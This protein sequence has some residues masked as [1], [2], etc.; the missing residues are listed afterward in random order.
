MRIA[1]ILLTLAISLPVNSS[2]PDYES[3]VRVY[4]LA[5]AEGRIEIAF[6][7]LNELQSLKPRY[8]PQLPSNISLPDKQNKVCWFRSPKD[9]RGVLAAKEQEISDL[10]AKRFARDF[11]QLPT[12][13]QGDLI[14]LHHSPFR[15]P[16]G[17]QEELIKAMS[18]IG[19]LINSVKRGP[20]DYESVPIEAEVIDVWADD[21]VLLSLDWLEPEEP[22]KEVGE[23]KYISPSV[24]I[25]DHAPLEYQQHGFEFKMPLVFVSGTE[26]YDALGGPTRAAVIEIVSEAMMKKLQKALR[27]LE[28]PEQKLRTWRTEDG[29]FSV[30]AKLLSFKNDVVGLEKADGIKI[31]VAL[32]KLA[33]SDRE[34]VQRAL[35]TAKFAP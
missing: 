12:W 22:P 5:G 24:A 30:E 26:V 27:D 17:H 18:Q 6:R 28:L 1:F 31:T 16:G 9:R 14:Y 33:I 32:E 8:N 10:K 20:L 15:I 34:F 3:I 11:F 21:R 19:Q 35:G 4:M 13:D 2:E 7:E 23:P 29:N 25:L